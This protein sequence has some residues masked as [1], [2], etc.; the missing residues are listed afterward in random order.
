MSKGRYLPP[1]V[2]QVTGLLIVV[3]GGMFWAVTGHESALVMGAG[4]SLSAL[5]AYTGLHV[6]ISQDLSAGERNGDV[7]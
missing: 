2:L 5:G 6:S 4:L 3:G 7:Q 1:F